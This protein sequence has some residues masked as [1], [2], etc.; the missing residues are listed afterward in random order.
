MWV[1]DMLTNQ[2]K[3]GDQIAPWVESTI[4][5]L[6][7]GMDL[8]DIEYSGWVF[9]VCALSIFLVICD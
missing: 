9:N 8:L 2:S 1:P 7:S 3:F 6:V 4:L 5:H